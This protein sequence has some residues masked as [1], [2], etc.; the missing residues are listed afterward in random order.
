MKKK[1]ARAMVREFHL[2]D[3]GYDFMGYSPYPGNRF[4]YH[5]LI[6]SKRLGGPITRWNGAILC[7]QTAHPY[8]HKIE[9]IDYDV[10]CSLTSEMIDMNFK[11][12]IDPK[13]IHM[14]NDIL[15]Y[16]EKEHCSDRDNSGE[17]SIKERYVKRYVK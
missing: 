14:I 4:T 1:A 12:Y 10:F 6:L 16:F 3:L 2:T 13:N 11:G 5:H 15:C 7:G 9:E 17:F 8:L